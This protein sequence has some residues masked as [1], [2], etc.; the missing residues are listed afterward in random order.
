[1]S[2]ADLRAEVLRLARGW[3]DT[4]YRHQASLRGVGT[5][6]LG[7]IRGIW[8][9]LYGAEPETLPAYTPDWAERAGEE[10]LLQA[11]ERWLMPIEDPQPG[12]I[13][14]FRMSASAP[15]K[16]IGLLSAPDTLLHAYW[17]KAVVESHLA[18]FWRRRHAYSFAFPATPRFQS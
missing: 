6:C 9:E 3:L 14:L 17:G 4:P 8:R 13:L 12:D 11:A 2:D 10:T 15:C 7:L 5:D 1:M 16:H 18:P